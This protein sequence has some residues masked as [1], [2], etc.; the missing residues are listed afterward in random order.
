MGILNAHIYMC[1]TEPYSYIDMKTRTH[2]HKNLERWAMTVY[3]C[4]THK[5]F[6]LQSCN[7]SPLSLERPCSPI[8]IKGNLI[9]IQLLKQS[10]GSKNQ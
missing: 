6:Q 1:V 10:G 5:Q 3:I 2:K 9:D 4:E 8:E 7:K